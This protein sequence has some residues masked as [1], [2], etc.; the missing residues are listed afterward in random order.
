[1]QVSATD[2]RRIEKASDLYWLW[3]RDRPKIGPIADGQFGE[4]RKFMGGLGAPFV[5]FK[6]ALAGETMPKVL[7]AIDVTV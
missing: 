1:V 2:L 7:T 6:E 3:W 4:I 5:K